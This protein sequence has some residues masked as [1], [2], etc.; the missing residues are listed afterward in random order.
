[1]D[2]HCPWINNCVG[3]RNRK[4]FILINSYIIL[5]GIYNMFLILYRTINSSPEYPFLSNPRDLFKMLIISGI[6]L[7][8]TF[9]V[10]RIMF[11]QV[12]NLLIGVNGIILLFILAIDKLK[13]V[14]DYDDRKDI[15]LYKY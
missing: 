6:L 2:H 3:L 5:Y 15:L 11:A 13:G 4:A 9:Y 8:F 12:Y 7:F 1:M 14:K 10:G